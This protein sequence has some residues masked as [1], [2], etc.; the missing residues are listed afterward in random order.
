MY[1][2]LVRRSRVLCEEQARAEIGED[3][4][5]V[6]RLGIVA[7]SHD[8]S[9]RLTY[10]PMRAMRGGEALWPPMESPLQYIDVADIARW[11]MQLCRQRSTV[12]APPCRIHLWVLDYRKLIV[13]CGLW[14]VDCELP[15]PA[16]NF[17]HRR[18]GSWWV[19]WACHLRRRQA[20]LPGATA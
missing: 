8:G 1:A 11:C 2:F 7:G 13:N 17:Q 10:W 4:L 14:I 9:G 5:L 6:L 3:R 15:Y 12:R 18:G 20:G 19:G 16:G